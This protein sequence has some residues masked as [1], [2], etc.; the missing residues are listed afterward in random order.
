M[1]RLSATLMLALPVLLA[2][3]CQ[4]WYSDPGI[5]D[6]QSLLRAVQAAPEAIPLDIYWARFAWGDA[7]M[8]D[9]L[10][11]SVQEDRIPV[12]V[13]RRLTANGLR[14]GVISG[15]PPESLVRLLAGENAIANPHPDDVPSA[16]S[17]LEAPRVSRHL[18]HFDPG[19]VKQ[20]HASDLLEQTTMLVARDGE[21][22][23][24][25]YQQAQASYAMVA[26]KTTANKVRVELTPE[27][28]HGQPRMKWHQ[29]QPGVTVQSVARERDVFDD[30]TLYAEL[31]AG[32]MLVIMNAPESRGLLGGVFHTTTTDGRQEQRVLLVRLS[33]HQPTDLSPHE[34]AAPPTTL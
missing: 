23:G 22:S 11:Q 18:A 33:Q 10:W 16:A 17:L 29:P 1:S 5:G 12:E 6:K 9:H 13:R 31:S 15:S 4:L 27:V 32:E 34:Q 2:S 26:A 8:N 28:I 24:R 3:G 21:L 25:T 14:A 19:K 20:E 30:L 7:D